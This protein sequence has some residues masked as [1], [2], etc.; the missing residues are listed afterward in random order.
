MPAMETI[1]KIGSLLV[2]RALLSTICSDA[3][4]AGD[5]ANPSSAYPAPACLRPDRTS[6]DRRRNYTAAPDGNIGMDRDALSRNEGV[7]AYNEGAQNYN[8]CM[9]AYIAAADIEKRRVHDQAIANIGQVADESNVRIKWIEGQIQ[10]I[11]NEANNLGAGAV[12]QAADSSQYPT[13][14]CKKPIEPRSGQHTI[15][16]TSK[17][18]QDYRAYRTCVS[19]YIEG[20]KAEIR[21]LGELAAGS[22]KRIA[23]DADIRVAA[24]T[25][26]VNGA[27]TEANKSQRSGNR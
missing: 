2:F 7:A 27:I 1:N 9:L 16:R 5:A 4:M 10:A 8:A 22:M 18:D 6:V 12:A 13:P 21:R 14:D 3:A 23:Q 11:V 15:E 24:I 20:A 17:Y 26:A 19:G 25:E